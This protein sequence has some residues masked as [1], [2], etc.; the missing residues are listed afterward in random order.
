[1]IESAKYIDVARVLRKPWNMRVKVI[2]IIIS[3]KGAVIKGL[4]KRLKISDFTGGDHLDE[5]IFVIGQNTEICPR[6]YARL[7][8]NQPPVGIHDLVLMEETR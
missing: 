7:V 2:L 6:D 3:V 4:E 5:R 1:M 8:V